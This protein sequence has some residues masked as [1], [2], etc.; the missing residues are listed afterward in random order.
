M[1]HKL[2][3]DPAVTGKLFTECYDYFWSVYKEDCEVCSA[4]KHDADGNCVC[5]RYNDIH[6]EMEKEGLI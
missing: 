5:A 3:W 2:E 6:A 4:H 1:P